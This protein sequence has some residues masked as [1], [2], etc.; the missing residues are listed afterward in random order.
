MRYSSQL[1]DLESGLDYH[2]LSQLLQISKNAAFRDRIYTLS[3]CPDFGVATSWEIGLGVRLE[4]DIEDFMASSEAV[5]LLAECFRG[6]ES[7]KNLERINLEH[8]EACKPAGHSLVLNALSLAKFSRK[9]AHLPVEMNYFGRGRPSIPSRT[10]ESFVPYVQG[11]VIRPR[12]SMHFQLSTEETDEYMLDLHVK[13]S[14][15]ATPIFLLLL[16]ALAGI[17]SLEL[18][19]CRPGPELRLCHGCDD[20]FTKNI[21][22]VRFP[23]LHALIISRMF[24][25]GSRL[26]GFIKGVAGTLEK[27]DVS[28]TMLTDGSWRSI[29][30]GLMKCPRLKSLSLTALRQRSSASSTSRPT[31]YPANYSIDFSCADHVEPYLKAFIAYF[32]TVLYL[33]ATRFQR[34]Y[35]K[36]YE[37]KL[38]LIPWMSE[39]IRSKE[40]VPSI[41]K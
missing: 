13:N 15:P 27:V 39:P 25:S 1:G 9:I 22:P 16:S 34:Q 28:Y 26:R 11:L 30:Q 31:H 3:L 14:R 5:H 17:D 24:I 29:A 10:P 36:Y 33:N 40:T 6:L 21:S 23:N 12:L 32:S 41:K 38:F 7:A 20:V 35:P 2:S 18:V 37:V 8:F 19:G 4:E